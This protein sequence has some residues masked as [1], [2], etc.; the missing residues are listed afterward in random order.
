[1]ATRQHDV[2]R[3]HLRRADVAADGEHDRCPAAQVAHLREPERQPQA[4]PAR[5]GDNSSRRGRCRRAPAK[6]PT[7]T[8]IV[9]AV[10]SIECDHAATGPASGDRQVMATAARGRHSAAGDE[11][12][13][14]LGR[15]GDVV[16][17]PPPSDWGRGRNC[18]TVVE[19]L[20][21]AGGWWAAGGDAIGRVSLHLGGNRSKRRSGRDRLGLR[22]GSRPDCESR[23]LWRFARP[24]L[25]PIGHE[26]KDRTRRATDPAQIPDR[27]ANRTHHDPRELFGDRLAVRPRPSGALRRAAHQGPHPMTHGPGCEH[28]RP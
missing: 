7:T 25:G 10:A 21:K 11:R 18:A 23:G 1:M 16:D 9:P 17:V 2:G 28:G 27:V 6:P 24:E 12:P 3:R 19:E 4:S 8:R 13:S 22:D 20:A 15:V 5:L 26:T 14:E